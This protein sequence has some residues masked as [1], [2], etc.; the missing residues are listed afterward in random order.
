[1]Y[2]LLVLI[3]VIFLTSGQIFWKMSVKNLDTYSFSSVVTVFLSPHFFIGAL[4]YALATL[5]WIFLLSKL[6]LSTLY[7]LQSL[8]YVFG[9]IAGYLIFKEL[10]TLQKVVGVSIILVGVFIVAK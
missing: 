4:L 1:M 3:N 2:I 5:I 8:A 7:P 6:P 9:L 10:I